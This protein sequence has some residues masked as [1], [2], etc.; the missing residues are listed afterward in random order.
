MARAVPV[1]QDILA[2]ATAAHDGPAIGII[3]H[4]LGIALSR[5]SL[6]P[7]DWE[8]EGLPGPPWDNGD[9]SD[10][11]THGGEE[12]DASLLI[13]VQAMAAAIKLFPKSKMKETQERF[14]AGGMPP[15]ALDGILVMA[16]LVA[17]TMTKEQARDFLESNDSSSIPGALLPPPAAPHPR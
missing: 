11:E 14:I 2:E 16:K 10:R 8:V 7:L 5:N 4:Y 9:E 12:M 17:R 1:L 13:A 6:P 15:Q 3:N